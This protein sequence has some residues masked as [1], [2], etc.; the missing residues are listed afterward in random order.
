MDTSPRKHWYACCSGQRKVQ[1]SGFYL[2]IKK[3][4]FFASDISTNSGGDWLAQAVIDEDLRSLSDARER[5]VFCARSSLRLQ[6][7]YRTASSEIR[8]KIK[9]VVAQ[10]SVMALTDVVFPRPHIWELPSR[11]LET[12]Q[13]SSLAEFRV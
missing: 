8:G 4:F 1:H 9:S 10:R 11:A 2:K 7:S 12:K 5:I 3:P 6:P 13:V